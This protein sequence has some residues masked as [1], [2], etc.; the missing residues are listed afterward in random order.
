LK[1]MASNLTVYLTPQ[2][3][4]NDVAIFR[5]HPL[6]D[7]RSLID[8]FG[9]IYP[10]KENGTDVLIS[11]EVEASELYETAGDLQDLRSVNYTQADVDKL[12]LPCLEWKDKFFLHLSEYQ[13][14]QFVSSPIDKWT[15]KTVPGRFWKLGNRQPDAKLNGYQN[16]AYMQ[17]GIMKWLIDNLPPV[18]ALRDLTNPKTADVFHGYRKNIR[19]A[20]WVSSTFPSIFNGTAPATKLALLSN[21]Q[22]QMGDVHDSIVSYNYYIAHED[23]KEAAKEKELVKEQWKKLREWIDLYSILDV[24][25]FI[26]KALISH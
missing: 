19:S 15:R 20:S 7:L 16:L 1:A 14:L 26:R 8:V 11:L 6:L 9:W 13:Y 23:H 2:T 12:L 17:S 3:Q 10:K 25:D 5:K 22:S 18:L 4:P 24:E 21:L